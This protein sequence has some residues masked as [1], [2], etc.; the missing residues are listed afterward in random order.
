MVKL[1]R[2]SQWLGSAVCLVSLVMLMGERPTGKVE[3]QPQPQVVAQ[4]SKL[5]DDVYVF[6]MTNYNSMFIVT[7]E[8]VVVVDPIGPSAPRC[9]KPRSPR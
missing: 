9:S 5:A 3:A 2:F 8:G 6:G 4:L 1:L 7:E